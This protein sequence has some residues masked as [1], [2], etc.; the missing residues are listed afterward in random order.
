[1]EDSLRMKAKLKI[2]MCSSEV[3]PFAKTGGLADV[4][5]S[6]P[7]FLDKLGVDI[8]IVMPKYRCVK[9]TSDETIIRENIDPVGKNIS[10]GV[11]AYFIKNDDFFNRDN[12]Y[13][14]QYG[15]YPDNLERFSFFCKEILKLIKE[16]NF[17]P[18]IIHCNDWQTALVPIYLKIL[19]KDDPILRNI[20][21]IFTIHNLA[22][23]GIFAKEKLP[24][25]GLSW[26]LFTIDGIEFYD[27]INLMKGALLF[28]D[29]ITT[30]SPT[31]S[32]QIQTK[33]Y[34]CGLDGVL[35]R[36]SKDLCG[37]INGIDYKEW[38]A[39]IDPVI[40]KNYSIRKVNNKTI[41]KLSLQNQTGLKEN[42][43]IPLFGIISRLTEQ[44]GIDLLSDSIDQLCEM[45]LQIVILGTGEEKY[46]QI[47]KNLAVKYP[48]QISINIKYDAE[49]AKKIY[50]GCDFFLMPSRFE[51]CGLGQL[52][53]L[54]YA[55]IPIVRHTG[56]L[57]DTVTEFNKKTFH[58]NGFVFYEYSS[59]DFITAV[60]RAIEVY[61]NKKLFK[62]LIKNAFECD[63]SWEKSA[64][65]YLELYGR[66]VK[67]HIG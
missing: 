66:M 22:Y 12:L 13:N 23:Q 15:D 52:I 9:V 17:I 57:A 11:K 26:D 35:S 31:Y 6:L 51:P 40:V 56:G 10:N 60:K 48:R 19:Y 36:R 44:K 25:T 33:E 65:K 16:K 14:D 38:N 8:R 27:K 28:S 24:K 43:N 49:F 39:S 63:F 37:I 55:T 59:E 58:G 34:G 4:A 67:S 32:R 62:R 29:L 42:R 20:K 7:L 3:V 53:S 21:T 61:S 1:M 41:N 18:D 46:H 50:A 2:L 64:N 54:R 47:L 45:G 30:V 5:G